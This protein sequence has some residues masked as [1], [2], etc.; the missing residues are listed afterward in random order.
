M[1][2]ESAVNRKLWKTAF[3]FL[4]LILC[5]RGGGE[6]KDIHRPQEEALGV[7]L[8]LKT[9]IDARLSQIESARA[10]QRQL[11]DTVDR[12]LPLF[13]QAFFLR[14]GLRQSGSVYVA[15][16]LDI[17]V[18]HPDVRRI[19]QRYPQEFQRLRDAA[20]QWL[21]G[22]QRSLHNDEPFATLEA[23]YQEQ[24]AEIERLS[25]C[26]RGEFLALVSAAGPHNLQHLPPLLDPRYLIAWE[27]VLLREDVS[28]AAK[29]R[30]LPIVFHFRDPES[31][32]TLVAVRHMA[33]EKRRPDALSEFP[34]LAHSILTFLPSQPT[35]AALIELAES[36]RQEQKEEKYQRAIAE[37]VIPPTTTFV[38]LSLAR[39]E[40]WKQFLDTAAA[41][42]D[43]VEYV[44]LL[45]EAMRLTAGSK[46]KGRD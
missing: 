13:E 26:P 38:G 27:A 42:K 2:G 43:M 18:L 29:E 9:L 25:S 6:P 44:A 45:R 5:D 14:R 16:P 19:V 40:E 11:F 32:A 35:R 15:G 8:L 4:G 22:V 24:H 30:L 39:S 41:E 12:Q 31:V 7:P 21:Q 3:L 33:L 1:V 46:T 36:V 34:R 10:E 20:T 23:A 37:G 28:W 17:N